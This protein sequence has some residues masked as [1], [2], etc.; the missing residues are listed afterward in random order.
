[1]NKENYFPQV[2]KIMDFFENGKKVRDKRKELR[3]KL[4]ELKQTTG[5]LDVIVGNMNR[6][7]YIGSDRTNDNNNEKKFNAT[8][9]GERFFMDSDPRAGEGSPDGNLPLERQ[10]S[11]GSKQKFNI[12]DY[13]IGKIIGRGTF[14]L[15]KLATHKKTKERFAFKIYDKMA[16]IGKQK[17]RNVQVS[18]FET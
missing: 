18:K 14:A 13:Q 15:V 17:Q 2:H 10:L 1:M 9:P 4:Q 16:M 7:N 11:Q 5:D 3:V 8:S 12:G 6:T